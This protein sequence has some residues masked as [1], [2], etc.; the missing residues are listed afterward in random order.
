MQVMYHD[1]LCINMG[2][3]ATLLRCGHVLVGASGQCGGMAAATDVN[4]SISTVLVTRRSGGVEGSD[5]SNNAR[6]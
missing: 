1:G 4:D 2:S 6:E 5:A 3:A